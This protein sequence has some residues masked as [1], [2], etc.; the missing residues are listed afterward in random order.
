LEVEG[1]PDEE[2]IPSS[3]FRQASKVGERTS[4]TVHPHIGE[5]YAKPHPSL[6][7]SLMIFDACTTKKE[8]AQFTLGDS[9]RVGIRPLASVTLYYDQVL[10]LQR[11]H[12]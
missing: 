5:G 11:A 8:L 6:L 10:R 1:I 12:V 7:F 4:V 3:R 2:T 9:T